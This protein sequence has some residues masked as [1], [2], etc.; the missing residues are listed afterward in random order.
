M[1]YLLSRGASV[2]FRFYSAMDPECGWNALAF[3]AISGNTEAVMLLLRNGTDV[4]QE[5]VDLGKKVTASQLAS[6]A[7]P[8]LAR[9]LAQIEFDERIKRGIAHGSPLP[10]I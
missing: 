2:H 10:N 9:M 8:D 7:Y 3:A 4:L 1:E 6:R 5:F